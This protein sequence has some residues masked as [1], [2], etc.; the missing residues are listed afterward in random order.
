MDYIKKLLYVSPMAIGLIYLV[1]GA[2]WIA[3][4][5]QFVLS[6]VDDPETITAIQTWKGW[7]FVIVSAIFIYI[8][9]QINNIKLG[10]VISEKETVQNEL[11]AIIEQAPVGIAYHKQ[12]EKWLRVNQQL[13]D[14]LGYN[15]S[16]LVELEFNDFIHPEDLEEGRELDRKLMEG[17][18]NSYKTEKKYLKKDGSELI[19]RL[20]KALIRHE[21]QAE[22]YVVSI[23]EDV[24][25]QKEFEKNLKKA[26]HEKELLLAEVHHRVNNNLALINGLL[27]LELN[28]IEN[29][30]CHNHFKKSQNRIKSIGI[31]HQKLYQAN[32]FSKLPLHEYTKEI[33]SSVQK[34]WDI[35]NTE[36]AFRS[37]IEHVTLN[38][39]QA[40]PCGLVLNELVTNAC[41]HAFPNGKK[42]P[43]IYV[44][45]HEEGNQIVITVS[46]NGI[47]LPS[48]IRLDES[49]TIGFTILNVLCK[50]LNANVEISNNPGTT[51]I[52][53][54]DKVRD[55]K[56]SASNL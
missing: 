36:I 1:L 18:E 27:E 43:E 38:V 51:F 55:K 35:G 5:D 32:D 2:L 49:D 8:L 12:D 37:D 33:L 54:F 34:N 39:N 26:L 52:I 7:G 11:E 3:F 9:V 50:Q 48:T 41:K 14:M 23:L 25:R 44:N 45:I 56:G 19:G 17:T 20:S 22:N 46:D 30:I 28:S 13:A 29:E 24:T 4:S 15:K 31:V 40:I 6:L 53:R 42:D 10:D 21:D 16:E 47:G